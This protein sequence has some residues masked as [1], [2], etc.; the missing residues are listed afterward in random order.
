MPE[1]LA[2]RLTARA[3][4]EGCSRND[5]IVRM[6]EL[7]LN[8]PEGQEPLLL[9]V[10]QLRC[11]DQLAERAGV[12]RIE[13]MRRYLS[14]RLRREFTDDRNSKLQDLRRAS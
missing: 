9:T 14:E 1:A 7:G 6:V 4:S 3:E 8:V 10:S 13:L 12:S 2:E 11:L 5:L